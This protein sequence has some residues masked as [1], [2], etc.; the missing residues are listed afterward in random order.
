MG[1]GISRHLTLYFLTIDSCVTPVRNTSEKITKKLLPPAE[2]TLYSTMSSLVLPTPLPNIA[3]YKYS[4]NEPLSQLTLRRFDEV[5]T[6][7][8]T[9]VAKS[10]LG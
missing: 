3:H 8:T 2:N 7:T 5:H 10:S 1:W 9:V 4:V 6:S